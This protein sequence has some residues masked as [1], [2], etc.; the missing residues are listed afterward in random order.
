MK[1]EKALK[2]SIDDQIRRHGSLRAAA[3]SLNISPSYL[4]RLH[5]GQKV[6]PTVDVLTKLGIRVK[7]ECELH[8]VGSDDDYGLA[9]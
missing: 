4:V 3:R 8:I 2:L 7:I 5:N 9:A 6:N 1:I